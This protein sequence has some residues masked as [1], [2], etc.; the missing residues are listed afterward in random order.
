MCIFQSLSSFTR[1]KVPARLDVAD[2]TEV[3]VVFDCHTSVDL[4]VEMQVLRSHCSTELALSTSLE[5]KAY[6]RIAC[7]ARG[8][9]RQ[10]ESGSPLKKVSL[11]A[12]FSDQNSIDRKTPQQMS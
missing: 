10:E 8:C 1:H 3:A 9:K 12:S 2:Y 5:E 6:L 4:Q 11:L 7:I